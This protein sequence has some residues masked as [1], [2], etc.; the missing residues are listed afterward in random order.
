MEKPLTSKQVVAEL[1]AASGLDAMQVVRVLDAL[2]A[3]ATREAG[4]GFTV[5]DLCKFKV[6]G[7]KARTYRNSRIQKEVLVGAHNVLKIVPARKLR[8]SVAPP[9]AREVRAWSRTTAVPES[10]G[11]FRLFTFHCPSCSQDIEVSSD[12]IGARAACP[13]CSAAITIPSDTGS[14]AAAKIGFICGGCKCEIETSAEL[15]GT[16]SACPG[17]GAKFNIPSVAGQVAALLVKDR[18][19]K[20]AP[21]LDKKGQ[22]HLFGRTMRIE[23]PDL[24]DIP[25]PSA[26]KASKT[27]ELEDLPEA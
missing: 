11:P 24:S 5:P 23:L 17:C 7:R 16:E 26:K 21:R 8:D 12:L 14:K 15:M 27:Q 4:R 1:A 2:T 20:E 18:T 13:A 10:Q 9:P 3:L 19:P 6:V 25:L 22:S